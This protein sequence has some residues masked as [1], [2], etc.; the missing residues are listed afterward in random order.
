MTVMTGVGEAV[1]RDRVGD[2][3]GL[4]DGEGAC[5]GE[6]DRTGE[7][8]GNSGLALGLGESLAAACTVGVGVG[9]AANV[10]VT[11]SATPKSSA[12]VRTAPATD[13]ANATRRKATSG[14]V[15]GV[16]RTGGFR[17]V[18]LCTRSWPDQGGVRR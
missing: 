9:V 14:M 11:A 2:G 6:A 15:G 12:G 8:S 16:N 17:V 18:R 4:G 13:A 5:D 10:A 1:R 7:G 3:D